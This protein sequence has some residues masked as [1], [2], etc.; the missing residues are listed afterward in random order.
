MIELW[1]VLALLSAV[2]TAIGVVIS[3][4]VLKNVD[5]KQLIFEENLLLVLI[6]LVF[7]FSKVEFTSIFQIWNL[8]LLKA[9]TLFGFRFLYYKLLKNHEVSSISPLMNLSPVF[10]I[11][12]SSIFLNEIINLTQFL[13]IVIIIV[14]TYFLEVNFHLH[15]DKKPISTYF[16]QLK[17]FDWK[18]IS[19]ACLMLIVI[20]F[21]AV[22]DKMILKIVTVETDLFFTAL[23]IFAGMLFYNIKTKNLIESFKEIK[24]NPLILVMSLFMAISNFLVLSAI[25]IP[26]AMVSLVVPVKRSSTLFSSLIGGVLF[27]ESHLLKKLLAVAFM[28]LG[29]FLIAL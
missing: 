11:V 21:C 27:H 1:I 24:S 29:V 6:V 17:K 9:G 18:M 28:L 8:F 5:S 16:S 4:K 2:F 19:V 12:I 26:T 25:A 10:L 13:G 3:K 22:A 7:F 14:S 15:H 20:S 23:L